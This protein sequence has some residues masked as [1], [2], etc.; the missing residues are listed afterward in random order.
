MERYPYCFFA[1]SV[2]ASFSIRSLD[3]GWGYLRPG[4]LCE[5]TAF[6]RIL[7]CTNEWI[8]RERQKGP[9]SSRVLKIDRLRYLNSLDDVRR[10]AI[11]L[12]KR[13]NPPPYPFSPAFG[14]AHLTITV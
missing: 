10:R 11:P 1:I 5:L 14:E 13:K 8:T 3:G 12:Q 4:G 6:G 9:L 2:I 7:D